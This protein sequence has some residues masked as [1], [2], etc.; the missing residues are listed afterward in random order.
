MTI[1]KL[2]IFAL[3]LAMTAPLGLAG[4]ASAATVVKPILGCPCSN[5]NPFGTIATIA[6]KT[7]NTYDFTFT[8]LPPVG[9]G[10]DTLS[11]LQASI[12]GPTPQLIDFTLFSNIGR[13]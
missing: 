2:A 7:G 12:K 13:C 5:G 1:R 11:Q 4:Q 3:G 8:L 6:L 9:T 10:I